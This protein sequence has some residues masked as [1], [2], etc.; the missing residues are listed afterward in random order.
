M[1]QYQLKLPSMGESVAE[2][3]VTRWLKQVGDPIE[4]DESVLEIATDK[5][6]SDVP[7]EVEGTLLE[8]KVQENEVAQV[9]DV[10]ALIEIEGEAALESSAEETSKVPE[11]PPVAAEE[12]T[13]A[14][15]TEELQQ[16]VQPIAQ[17]P[18]QPLTSGDRFYSPLVKNI[19]QKEGISQTELDQIPGSGKEGRVTKKDIL[20]YLE[21]GSTVTPS[22][23]AVNESLEA[24]EVNPLSVSKIDASKVL[25]SGTSAQNAPKEERIIPMDRMGQLI[26]EHMIRSLQTSAH[27]QSFV[28]VDV[29]D[30][31]DWREKVKKRFQENEGEKLTFTPMFMH[32]VIQ[33]LKS[34][35]ILN[36][37][38]SGT[39]IIQKSQINLGM[40]AALPDGNLI[41]PV[42]KNADHLNLVG[43]AKAVN[44]LSQRARLGKLRPEE[45]Q[46]GTYTV[47]NVGNFGSL[48]G[49][50]IINQPQVGILAIGVIRKVP[51]VIETPEGDF[52]G[53][54]KK[55]MLCH[56]YDHRIINGAQGG[57]F[58]K[59]V[60]DTLEQWDRSLYR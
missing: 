49:T 23:V 12:T 58:A 60:A 28:E 4:L 18:T 41:V 3:T 17:N 47:T 56:S 13:A 26:S 22:E 11:I 1:G 2:A 50:P 54:R 29:T 39:N 33:A 37:S 32:A 46:G 9:G 35:P 16:L 31:W 19:A 7:S 51:A 52:I 10:L 27:V 45:A 36:S 14:A 24:P 42:I 34:Y 20:A 6:D 43:L 53:I 44:D 5:V 57:L 38:V 55:M 25:N 15:Y 30:L 21:Q 59:Q 48:T 8:I 40:A